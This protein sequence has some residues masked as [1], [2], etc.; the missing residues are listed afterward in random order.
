VISTFLLFY[1]RRY[2][3]L[4]SCFA[5]LQFATE[6]LLFSDDL[7]YDSLINQLSYERIS[8]LL[9][10]GKK[11]KWLSYVFV[12]IVFLVKATFVATCLSI[13][14]I[15]A[16]VEESFAKFF[17]MAV[18][19]E[20]IFLIPGIIKLLWFSFFNVNYTLQ[21]LQYFSPLSVLSILSQSEI[22]PMFLYPIQLLN[23]FEVAYWFTIAYQLKPILE[24]NFGYSLGFL[25][26]TYGVGLA[27][28]VVVVMFL[29]VSI[30]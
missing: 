27:V 8:E 4:V 28:W 22:E 1:M 12:P 5:G 25:A 11:W 6:T 7:I 26:K 3:L 17:S 21:D 9:N 20:F 10:Q 24:K 29:T 15:F 19:A 16:R 30:S 2:L 23:L 13:G 14:G 18:N